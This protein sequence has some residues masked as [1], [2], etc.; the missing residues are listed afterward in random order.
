MPDVAAKLTQSIT[1]PIGPLPSGEAQRGFESARR[2]DQIFWNAFWSE[3]PARLIQ[4]IQPTQHASSGNPFLPYYITNRSLY[5]LLDEMVDKDATI[6]GTEDTVASQVL[7]REQRIAAP[8]GE[9]E[10]ASKPIVEFVE[11]AL[12]GMECG[13]WTSALKTL[14]LGAR[15]HGFAVSEIIYRLDGGFYKPDRIKH[16][17]PGEFDFAINGTLLLNNGTVTR[18]PAP[19]NRFIIHRNA[20]MY[21]NPYGQSEIFPLRWAYYFKKNATKAWIDGVETFGLPV[22]VGTIEAMTEGDRRK[23]EL[24]SVMENLRA[25]SGVV[26]PSGVTIQG[27]ARGLSQ[28]GTPHEALV[29]YLDRLMVRR[30]T[31]STLTTMENAGTGSLAQSK[32]H[33]QIANDRLVSIC[34]SLA[35]T[36]TRDLITPLVRINFGPNAVV[37][38]LVIDTD[39]EEDVIP[40]L[41]IMQ[42][43]AELGVPISTSQFREWFGLEPPADEGDTIKPVAIGGNVVD[44]ATAGA[45]ASAEAVPGSLPFGDPSASGPHAI[46]C[47]C[48][49]GTRAARPFFFAQQ[50]RPLTPSSSVP[51]RAVRI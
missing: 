35:E 43:A 22:L 13:K 45:V 33:G 32:T 46:G 29:D 12:F 31:G 14:L 17:H 23:S 4:E 38:R 25:S 30:L 3:N 51:G 5:D 2:M 20:A 10:E 6:G 8:E 44:P 19:P 15:R 42:K 37:P 47:P 1:M 7:A 16:C 18:Q 34:N 21:D 50:I 9:D 40:A 28:S 27:I 48:G 11:R 41:A 39:E 26:V 49:C 36:I 24:E